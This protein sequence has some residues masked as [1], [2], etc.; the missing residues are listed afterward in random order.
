MRR[1]TVPLSPGSSAIFVLTSDSALTVGFAVVSQN[2]PTDQTTEGAS[3]NRARDKSGFINEQV[4]F[5][6]R[7]GEDLVAQ[8]AALPAQELSRA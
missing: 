6:L 5:R 8:V 2:R 1:T 3:Q 7:S 4:T